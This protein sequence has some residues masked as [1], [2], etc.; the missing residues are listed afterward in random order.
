MWDLL[1]KLD[2]IQLFLPKIQELVLHDMWFQQDGATCRTARVTMGLLR[3]EFGGHFISRSLSVNWPA[4]SFD[5]I[6]LKNYL[7][8]SVKAHV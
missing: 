6:P 8:G 7:W 4:R 2:D 1:R 5:L 3:G